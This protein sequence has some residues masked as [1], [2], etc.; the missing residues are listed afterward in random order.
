M[1]GQGKSSEGNTKMAL[2]KRA[3]PPAD[4]SKDP[5]LVLHLLWLAVG[6][7]TC[8]A[9][10]ARSFDAQTNAEHAPLK[11][12]SHVLLDQWGFGD[13]ALHDPW[14]GRCQSEYGPLTALQVSRCVLSW[15]FGS[16]PARWVDVELPAYQVHL[17]V[18]YRCR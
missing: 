18:P 17:H 4:S 5:S 9:G 1:E 6:L 8:H 15:A 3:V 10:S 2:K 13:T 12:V 7:C 16:F 11:D 14:C